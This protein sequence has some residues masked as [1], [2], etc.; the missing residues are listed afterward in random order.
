MMVLMNTD[1]VAA[2]FGTAPAAMFLTHYLRSCFFCMP[3]K[4]RGDF[5][6]ILKNCGR[7]GGYISGEN[8]LTSDSHRRCVKERR[9]VRMYS[10]YFTHCFMSVMKTDFMRRAMSRS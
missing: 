4:I 3:A 2:R 6:E 9:L 5:E 10:E 7:N 8:I 1:T